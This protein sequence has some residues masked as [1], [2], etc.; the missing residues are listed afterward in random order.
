MSKEPEKP[1]L[2]QIT[3]E[4]LFEMLDTSEA[5]VANLQQNQKA[6]VVENERLHREL[7]AKKDGK[8]IFQKLIDVKKDLTAIGKGKY[9]NQGWSF[10]GIDDLQKALKPVLDKHEVGLRLKCH[11]NAEH[12][13]EG[14]DY[15]GKP[16]VSKNTRILMEYIAFAGDGSE[17]PL[18]MVPAE[19]IDPGDKG[20]NKALSY[21][22]KY[23]LIQAFCVPTEDQEEGDFSNE[24]ISGGNKRTTKKQEKEKT[25]TK[26]ISV[27][28]KTSEEPENKEPS[29]FRRNK[30]PK[31]T[32]NG[33]LG[34]L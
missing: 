26:E 9:N 23:A 10:R 1:D 7:L 8:Q 33:D 34:A 30:K 24:T 2:S 3:K 18:A 25:T 14:V 29:S 28:I 21:A 19:G 20:T 11:Q 12:Y 6:L 32:S 15:K 4:Q 13:Q 5:K 27:E 22:M 17:L 16:K 31:T